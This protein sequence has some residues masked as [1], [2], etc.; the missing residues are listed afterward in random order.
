MDNR[1]IKFR[2]WNKERLS[3]KN[4]CVYSINEDC[5]TE[6]YDSLAAC[7]LSSLTDCVEN[8]NYVIQEFTGLLDKNSKEIYEGDIIEFYTKFIGIKDWNLNQIKENKHIQIVKFG[9]YETGDFSDL[10]LGWYLED[11][12]EN[13]PDKESLPSKIKL[14]SHSWPENS[15]KCEKNDYYLIGNIFKNPD[16]L[17]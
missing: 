2:V 11:L 13:Y 7:F 5:P 14:Y 4:N 1:I 15:W 9:E 16:L 8:D 10:N 12:K 17:K 3:F 6:Y